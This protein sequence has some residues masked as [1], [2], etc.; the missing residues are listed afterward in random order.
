MT[1]RPHYSQQPEND[2]REEFEMRQRSSH[3]RSDF[4]CDAITSKLLIVHKI[5]A[6]T[7]SIDK[8]RKL[9]SLLLKRTIY[10]IPTSNGKFAHEY[11]LLGT[12]KNFTN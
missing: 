3:R 6:K 9:I 5:Y 2:G 12:G 8:W 1:R 7:P 10:Y 11:H 4:N